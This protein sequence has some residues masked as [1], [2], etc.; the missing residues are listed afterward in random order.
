MSI[1][2]FES[3]SHYMIVRQYLKIGLYMSDG[4]KNIT[5]PS[6]VKSTSRSL[7]IHM[8]IMKKKKPLGKLLKYHHTKKIM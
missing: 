1:N 2:I 6:F 8:R 4:E 3:A 5:Y 7:R